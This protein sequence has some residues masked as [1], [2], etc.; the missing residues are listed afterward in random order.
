MQI[1]VIPEDIFFTN[2]FT[3]VAELDD[4]S[5]TAAGLVSEILTPG[6]MSH[7]CFFFKSP[8]REFSLFF[9][10]LGLHTAG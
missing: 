5:A 3:Q 7:S 4:S 8:G 1:P 9:F 10:F 2:E 6:K